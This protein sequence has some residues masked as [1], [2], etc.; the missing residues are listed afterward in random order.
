MPAKKAAR[1]NNGT[2]RATGITSMLLMHRKQGAKEVDPSS[3]D[4]QAVQR[5]Q[6]PPIDIEDKA[7]N[8][9]QEDEHIQGIM[10]RILNNT[11]QATRLERKK[12][13][14][15]LGTP[16]EEVTWLGDYAGEAE[17]DDMV[18]NLP[19]PQIQAQDVLQVM[20]TTESPP[21]LQPRK[22]L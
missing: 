12:I 1:K 3:H 9:P 5:L 14:Q 18:P 21:V 7:E 20:Q 22:V 4:K 13:Y 11:W 19:E 10:A 2:D 6:Q 17:T 16:R 15:H 8:W